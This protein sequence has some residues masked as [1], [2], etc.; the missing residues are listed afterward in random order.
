MVHVLF[1]LC[2]LLCGQWCPTHL[3]ECFT[4]VFLRPS[5]L[6]IFIA[7]SVFP[8]VYLS[9]LHVPVHDKCGANGSVI[10]LTGQMAPLKT[11][12]K[13]CVSYLYSRQLSLAFWQCRINT[14]CFRCRKISDLFTSS[15]KQARSFRSARWFYDLFSH[16]TF[17][18]VIK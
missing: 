5:G 18:L 11:I 12:G 7:L 2:V 15:A 8:N 10:M 16:K 4:F 9:N 13:R 6:P 1:T 14:I 3:V 17:P